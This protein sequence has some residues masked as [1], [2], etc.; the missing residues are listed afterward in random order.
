MKKG[1]I[2][3]DYACFSEMHL[4]TTEAVVYSLVAGYCNAGKRFEN[5][6]D[7]M[8]LTLNMT[9]RGLR[10]VLTRL[11]DG[12]YLAKERKRFS[13]EFILCD[14]WKNKST[15]TA[16]SKT[17]KQSK[18]SNQ[19]PSEP[20]SSIGQY[21]A[22]ILETFTQHYAQTHNGQAYAP[23]FMTITSVTRNLVDSLRS[24]MQHD[25]YVC[26]PDTARTYFEQWLGVAWQR[27]DAWHRQR[28]SMEFVNSQFNYFHNIV[29]NG[30][31]SDNNESIGGFT[32]D[33]FADVLRNL[34]S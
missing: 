31:A 9:G 33:D 14:D 3:I 13:V 29:T 15:S 10:K 8:A 22:I 18:S 7:D 11:C 28:W 26:N 6:I 24:A 1:Y 20:L 27:A 17:E 12:G 34:Q 32:A 5:R 4:N 30:T 23:N 16:K 25:N 2:H 19:R 21:E